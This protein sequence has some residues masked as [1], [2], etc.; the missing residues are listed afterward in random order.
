MN[1]VGF[2]EFIIHLSVIVDYADTQA[3]FYQ[4]TAK[5]NRPF[6][7]LRRSHNL[8]SSFPEKILNNSIFCFCINHQRAILRPVEM[9]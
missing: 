7:W 9:Q 8:E 5:Y 4:L 3:K 1:F 2:N 6:V